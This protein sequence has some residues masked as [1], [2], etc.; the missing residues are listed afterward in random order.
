MF[1]VPHLSQRLRVQ[2]EVGRVGPA[3]RL[4]HSLGS[5]VGCDVWVTVDGV[6][7]Y[8]SLWHIAQYVSAQGRGRHVLLAMC[9][10]CALGDME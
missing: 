10:C 9:K 2:N 1:A 7:P 4:D 5:R 8:A 6:L 3:H